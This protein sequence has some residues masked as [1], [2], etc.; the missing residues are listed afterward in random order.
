[1][2]I[3]KK[4]TIPLWSRRHSSR[5]LKNN[6]FVIYYC[7]LIGDSKLSIWKLFAYTLLINSFLLFSSHETESRLSLSVPNKLSILALAAKVRDNS[8]QSGSGE[9]HLIS[10]VPLIFLLSAFLITISFRSSVSV[11]FCVCFLTFRTLPMQIVHSCP[12]PTSQSFA[13]CLPMK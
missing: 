11:C 13:P 8:V 1:M 7:S 10:L 3:T 6:L 5:P 2:Y 4:N 12:V 9:R